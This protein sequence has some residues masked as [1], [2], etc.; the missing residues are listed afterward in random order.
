VD[1]QKSFRARV[2]HPRPTPDTEFLAPALFLAGIFFL[3]FMSRLLIAPL[4][5]VIE[6]DLS[7]GHGA[8]GGLFL[9]ITIGYFLSMAGAGFITSR[10][11]HKNAIVLSS[12]AL[13]LALVAS[14]LSTGAAGMYAGMTLVGMAAGLY[15]P[16]GIATLTSLVDQRRWGMAVAIHELAPNMGFVIAPVASNLLI[17]PLGWRGILSLTG[18]LAL[19]AGILHLFFGRG[20]EFPGTPPNPQT[21]SRYFSTREAWIMVVLFGLGIAGS[22]GIYTMLPLF[23]VSSHAMSMGEANILVTLSRIS[24]IGMAFAAGW[25]AD[26][27]GL[28]QVILAVLFA[29]GITSLM[30]GLLSGP[31]LT[32]AV[33][34][35]PVFAVSF[36]PAGFSALSRIGGDAQ[37]RNVAVSSTVP[38][39][40]ILGGGLVPAGIGLSGDLGAFSAGITITGALILAGAFLAFLLR[41]PR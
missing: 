20:G 6:E 23:L 4:M 17:A 28:R 21:I 26:R 19:A 2:T 34:L 33:F 25:A 14:A 5:P 24:G 22:L 30:I 36:F 18:I 41:I 12:V 7:L 32:A 37:A 38:L 40:F 3:N 39:A 27:F 9:S 1:A 13:G 11:T 16:S 35:Q 15:L 8:A 31:R 10:I 29:T